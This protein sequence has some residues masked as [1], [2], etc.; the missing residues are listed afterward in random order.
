MS[1]T[2]HHTQM[3]T[4]GWSPPPAYNAPFGD[5]VLPP[6]ACVCGC[7]SLKLENKAFCP[8]NKTDE[9]EMQS[10]VL[11]LSCRRYGSHTAQP[12]RYKSV[13]R[14]PSAD[15]FDL[16][17]IPHQKNHLAIPEVLLHYSQWH[18]KILHCRWLVPSAV[19]LPAQ[20]SPSAVSVPCGLTVLHSLWS[21]LDALADT[22]FPPKKHPGAYNW[23]SI[24]KNLSYLV[25]LLTTAHERYSLW[26]YR[27]GNLKQPVRC[28][29]S[30]PA[31]VCAAPPS[32]P[33]WQ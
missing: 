23:S 11:R 18:E 32:A 20:H 29:P 16:P 27:H 4:P 26:D 6:S 9:Y 12:Y 3:E 17:Y 33:P 10:S 8:D 28:L 24:C 7:P 19:F 21:D 15:I 25:P 5:I 14:A 22:Y 31:P 30:P 1:L 2:V 13:L